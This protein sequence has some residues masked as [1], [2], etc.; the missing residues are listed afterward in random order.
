MN[1]IR[2][3]G[4]IPESIVDGPGIRYT[5]FSQGCNHFCKGCHN[6]QTHDLNGGRECDIDD[7]LKDIMKNPLLRGVTF[8]GGEPFL[9]AEQFSKLAKFIKKQ[10]LNIVTYTGYK[11]EDLIRNI[12]NKAGWR[13]LLENTDILIDGPYEQEKR[14]LML[15]F[16]GSENQRIL[17]AQASLANRRAVEKKLF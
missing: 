10:G 12:N 15:R 13:E 2:I 4:I 14:N 7:I 11:F 3:S 1:K 8:S 6:P 17:D 16:R 5:I 9:Q